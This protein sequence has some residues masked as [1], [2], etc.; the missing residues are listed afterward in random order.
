MN[1][2][3][4]N[5]GLQRACSLSRREL[6]K[7]ILLFSAAC[8][9]AV[10]PSPKKP[11]WKT[12]VGLNGFQ[13][14]T[15]KYKKTYPIWEV[16][17]F[18]AGKGFDG[19]ELV[20]DWPMGA[21][22]AASDTDRIEALRKFWNSFGV[23]IFSLQLPVPGSFD[24]SQEKRQT[25][26]KMFEDRAA[27]ARQLGCECLGMWPVGTLGDQ[28]IEQ[29]ISN[30]GSTYKAAAGIAEKNGLLAAFEIEPPFVFNTEAHIKAILAAADHPNLKT[31]YDPSHFDLMNGSTGKPHEM[32][33]R[34]GVSNIGY[35][36]FTDCDGTK[37]DG[38]TSKHLGAGDGHIDVP[39]SLRAL[40]EGGFKGWM[41]V[42]TWE[43][44][45]PYDACRKAMKAFRAV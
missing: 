35:V 41:M 33:L 9:T 21:Y 2:N 25:W 31:I 3:T 8:S 39:A 6:L 37:R 22:P 4:L 30:L 27:L 20:Q 40:R 15:H 5:T 19:V 17:N 32:L 24:A 18:I 38:G 34:I 28:T 23:Q 1:K 45:D 12:A 11:I 16:A 13:S 26:L 14:G 43:I 42:D 36:H 44:P 7:S 10:E 29:A